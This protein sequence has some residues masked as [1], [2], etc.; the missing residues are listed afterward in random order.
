MPEVNIKELKA[1]IETFVATAQEKMDALEETGK[2]NSEGLAK[3]IEDFTASSEKL[4]EVVA[5]IEAEE[6]E[7]KSL[8]SLMARMPSKGAG[9]EEFIGDPDLRSE[10]KEYLME[11]SNRN[12]VATP[13]SIDKGI[14]QIAE[15]HDIQTTDKNLALLKAGLVGSNPDLGY[16]API[17]P[18]RFIA[19]RLFETSPVR[20]VANVISTA[21]EAAQTIID[22]QEA[23]S[24]W[25]AELDARPE[26]TTPQI[27]ELEIPTHEQYAEPQISTKA[28][29]DVAFNAESWLQGKVVDKFSRVENTAF[30]LGTGVK[31]PRGIL[32]YDGWATAEQYERGKLEDV[33]TA[34]VGTLAADDLIDVQTA[35]LEG[36][37]SN[38]SWMMSR[39]IWGDVIKLK[40]TTNNYLINLQ[41]L[42]QG[43]NLQLLGKTVRFAGDMATSV[44][45]GSRIALYGDFREGYMVVDRIGI[46]V[47]RDP[48]TD[49]RVV[50]FYTTKR[51]G[52]AVVNYQAIKRLL[53]QVS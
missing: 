38:A 24:G 50:K 30:M 17:D 47:L 53:V 46:R 11:G 18:M 33:E 13:E 48:F 2:T 43:V 31:Q 15:F 14:I 34:T 44:A 6:N 23:G 35:L 21:R 5:R 22:D 36:Y 10:F 4:S 12:P 28:L 20:Q 42:F 29:D 9:D 1:D 41:L 40:D 52:G 45:E 25:V 39:Q 3:V 16:L 32:D 37:Q 49:K 8:E 19:R 26:T 51:V 27:A 7:R